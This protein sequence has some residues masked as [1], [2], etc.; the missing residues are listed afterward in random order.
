LLLAVNNERELGSDS[1]VE[2]YAY[3]L[4]TSYPDS[5]QAAEVKQLISGAQGG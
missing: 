5:P 2:H 3:L 4:R 1:L